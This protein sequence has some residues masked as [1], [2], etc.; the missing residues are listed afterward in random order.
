[1]HHSTSHMTISLAFL[2]P[3]LLEAAIHSR[4]PRGIGDPS[5][6]RSYRV[7]APTRDARLVD[8]ILA[9][10]RVR[11]RRQERHRVAKSLSPR[12]QQLAETARMASNCGL[13]VGDRK[14]TKRPHAS[15]LSR[16]DLTKVLSL[17]C[18][19]WPQSRRFRRWRTSASAY[20]SADKSVAISCNEL[21]QVGL[22]AS[23][24]FRKQML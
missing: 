9:I 20:D 22:A 11:G 19:S 12:S 8:L 17:P 3:E 21:H 24:R 10:F 13:F 16:D 23:R 7:V 5:A 15:A 4:P 1:M 2:A 6:R 18:R 14:T